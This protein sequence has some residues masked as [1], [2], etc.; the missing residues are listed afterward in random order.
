MT[1]LI[2][3]QYE[4]HIARA[5]ARIEGDPG[6]RALLDPR[7]DPVLLERFLIQYTSLGVQMT[8]PVEGWIRRAGERCVEV[9]L[10]DLGRSL[11]THARHEGGHHEMLM[12]DTRYL[13]DR[14]NARRALS[15]GYPQ[16]DAERALAARP[17]QAIQ[18][19]VR[20]HEDTIASDAPF[21]QIAIE[22]EI[23]RLSVVLGPKL[24]AQFRDVLGAEVM[25][26]LSFLEEHVA[27]DVGHTH[28]NEKMLERLLSLR[29]SG[30]GDAARIPPDG[31]AILGKT[32]AAALE[33][34]IDFFNDC[35]TMARADLKRAALAPA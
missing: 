27:I 13:V 5:R 1:D 32:G 26:G 33:I 15:E 10:G 18:A 9:G 3:E 2:K 22:Y 35:L 11:I 28:L 16:L 19:Y 7:V 30:E 20:I 31:A 4:P 14:W 25:R 23:E 17:T 12:K 8:E 21:A 24:I 29:S 34:Y 6:L